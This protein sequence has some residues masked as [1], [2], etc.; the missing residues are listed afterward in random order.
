M[1]S[2]GD[3]IADVCVPASSSSPESRRDTN[4]DLCGDL[5][6]ERPNEHQPRQQR[7][8]NCADGVGRVDAAHQTRRVL[9]T[10]GDRCER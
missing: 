7:A 8:D 2:A 9:P 3:G 4:E 5:A 10:F 1:T 6:P